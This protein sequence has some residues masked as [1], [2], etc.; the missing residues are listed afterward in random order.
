[1]IRDDKKYEYDRED[2]NVYENLFGR[3]DVADEYTEAIIEG[4]A[5]QVEA[6]AGFWSNLPPAKAQA[7]ASFLARQI[8][9]TGPLAVNRAKALASELSP[10]TVSALHRRIHELEV[11]LADTQTRYTELVRLTGV[12]YGPV[13]TGRHA[14]VGNITNWPPAVHLKE[15]VL[16]GEIFE[17]PKIPA[18]M[19]HELMRLHE[20][21]GGSIFREAAELIRSQEK[22]ISRSRSR[23]NGLPDD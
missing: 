12:N 10:L 21:I 6:C 20:R 17:A 18:D 15:D 4:C 19:Y 2:L 23:D 22:I 13:V 8:R 5:R 3:N 1:M 7:L 14:N 16:T 9:T 11:G